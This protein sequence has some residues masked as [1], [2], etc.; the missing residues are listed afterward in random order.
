MSAPF[1]ELIAGRRAWVARAGLTELASLIGRPGRR[2]MAERPDLVARVDQHAA[3]IRDALGGALIDPVALA[4][5]AAAIQD[6]ASA[7][8]DRLDRWDQPTWAQLR[9]LAVCSVGRRHQ[10]RRR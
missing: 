5:Y 2:A 9:L 1:D 8:G 10:P 6:A 7:A 3:A 4:G